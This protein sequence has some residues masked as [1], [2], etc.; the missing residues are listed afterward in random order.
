MKKKYILISLI[1]F[2]IIIV[3][4]IYLLTSNASFSPASSNLEACKTLMYN[5]ENKINILF[6][7]SKEQAEKYSDYFLTI[8]PF[9]QNK[10]AF[11]FY[12]I[13]SYSPACELYS[14]VALLCY[15]KELIKKSSSCPN[16]YII[17]IK[18]MNS[19]IRSSSYMNI[20]SINSNLPLS[21][22]PHEFGHAF[23]VLAEEYTPATIPR[24]SKNCVASCDK[25]SNSDGC[26]QG[27][28][29]ENY[30][31]S[32]ENGIMRTLYTDNYGAFD[33][34][35]ISEKIKNSNSKITGS[36]ILTKADCSNKNY[37]LIEGIY[38][39]GKINI[40]KKTIE[41]GCVG[42]N[43]DG[44]F[45]Y[46]LILED[47]SISTD[48]NFNPELI[49]TDGQSENQNIISGQTYDSNK[50]FYLKIPLTENSKSLQISKDNQIISEINLQNI[51]KEFCKVK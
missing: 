11:N 27:C 12:Y 16:D 17:V 1:S 23:A 2:I 28:S 4:I 40:L 45:E 47:N 42:T 9:S 3:S 7:S 5:G 35:L 21:V 49:F 50:P 36:A 46:K 13:N 43:G 25:F 19:D 38:S 37:Y 14:G 30:Y 39:E 8:N 20:L 10:D 31:R 29:K 33:E 32:I 26:F 48:G 15:S 41:W 6:F 18:N 44:F 24:G 34:K 51:G 22:L